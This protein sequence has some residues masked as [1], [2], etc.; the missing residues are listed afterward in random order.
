MKGAGTG[1]GAAGLLAW[2]PGVPGRG[3]VLLVGGDLPEPGPPYAPSLR[4]ASI[5]GALQTAGGRFSLVIVDGR[6]LASGPPRMRASGV[7][8]L[9]DLLEENGACL[10]VIEGS[11]RP[12]SAARAAEG[13]LSNHGLAVRG[14]YGVFPNPSDPQL[15][16]PMRA[17]GLHHALL[18]LAHKPWKRWMVRVLRRAGVV[19]ILG[20]AVPAIVVVAGPGTGGADGGWR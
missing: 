6:E 8:S 11:N 9:R 14:V 3:R 12:R 13:V 18:M 5:D 10:A 17:P 15:S 19:G 7:G 16:A 4:A 2:L 20:R 1:D